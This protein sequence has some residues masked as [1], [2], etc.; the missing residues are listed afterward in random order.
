MSINLKPMDRLTTITEVDL[1]P[2]LRFSLPSAKDVLEIYRAEV[3]DLISDYIKINAEADAQIA[4]MN[5]DQK[6]V[7][8]HTMP[9]RQE[10]DEK[11]E[12]DHSIV[13]VEPETLFKKLLG[14]LYD[15]LIAFGEASIRQQNQNAEINAAE[16]KRMAEEWA[17]AEKNQV[18][19]WEKIK[20]FFRQSGRS[21]VVHQITSGN[22]DGK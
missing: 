18:S 20:L 12:P 7:I 19:L 14:V 17:A 16:C 22:S 10:D 2:E 3:N 15:F 13:V 4:R 1:Q 9:D 11:S 21:A 5:A 6:T 8:C